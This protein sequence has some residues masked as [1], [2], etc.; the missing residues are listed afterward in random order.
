MDLRDKIIACYAKSDNLTNDYFDGM[1]AY[2][3]GDQKTGDKKFADAE[4]YYGDAFHTCDKEVI[5]ALNEWKEK[6]DDLSNIKDWDKISARIYEAHKD[7]LNADIQ[8]EF[9]WWDA[10][11]YF[12]SGMYAG[13]FQKVF[14]DDAPNAIVDELLS[15]I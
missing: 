4:S 6:V 10:A 9:K 15:L 8:L 2:E 11:V 7:E 13:R 12:N 5:D 3:A 1:A 14:L